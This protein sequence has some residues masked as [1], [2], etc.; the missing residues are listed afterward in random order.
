MKN[1]NS[2]GFECRD[3]DNFCP[4]CGTKLPENVEIKKQDSTELSLIKLKICD[5]CGEENPIEAK[6][7]SYCGVRFSGEEKIV[8]RELALVEQKPKA[9][10]DYTQKKQT[11]TILKKK[12][13]SKEQAKTSEIKK[14]ETKH[15]ILIGVV[16]LVVVIILFFSGYEG[17]KSDRKNQND[18][19]INS[20]INL[21][22]INEINRLEDELKSDPDNKEKILRLAHLN[23]DSGFFE[24][25]INY[26]ERYLKLNPNDND[27]EVDLGVC[28]FELKQYEKAS[29]I[30]ERVIKKNPKHQIAYLN[31][32]IVHLTQ[33]QVD[34][35]KEFFRK[36]IELGEHTDAGHR[37][38][39][40]LKSH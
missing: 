2:C 1:C 19:Q 31:L 22:A 11:K 29:E 6:E 25:A 34:R 10:F 28:F 35:A 18:Q 3:T 23:H 37:A 38:A 5:L 30:F 26:Y 4:N 12:H 15:F 32:G 33:G 20:G 39:E 24:K 21:D 14:L 40:L 16:A 13:Q 9:E 36:C 7:C 17:N 27:A 8:E